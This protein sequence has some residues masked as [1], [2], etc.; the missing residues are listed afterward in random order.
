MLLTIKTIVNKALGF[1]G[2]IGR[3]RVSAAI[4]VA[5]VVLLP[6]R[7]HADKGRK[8]SLPIDAKAGV[9][10]RVVAADSA[11]ET[12]VLQL[13]SAGEQ[14]E[15]EDLIV[16]E[17]ARYPEAVRVAQLIAR[18]Q[19]D[20][21]QA[22]KLQNLNAVRPAQSALFLFACCTRSR[23]AIESASPFFNVVWM[24]DHKTPAAKCAYY[25]MA[26]DSQQLR[27][28]P[29]AVVD[30]VFRDLRKLADAHPDNLMIRWMLAVQ[31]RNWNRDEEGAEAYKLVLARWQPGPA[32]VHQT[33]ANLLDNLKRYDEALAERYL[34]VKMEPASW[35]YDGLANTLD[36]LSRFDESCEIHEIAVRMG[37]GRSLN[38]SNWAVALNGQGKHEEAIEKCQRALHL[39]AQNWRAHWMWGKALDGQGKPQEALE[40]CQTATAI[41]E[42]PELNDYI[43]DLKRRLNK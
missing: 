29:A 42:F 27:N 16:S 21:A 23:F 43:A 25:M 37:P 2:S 1:C 35:S 11:L 34:V 3:Y 13:L 26:M 9:N 40:K 41:F 31:C 30:R 4:V 33:Y 38:W 18:R 5:A 36:N 14:S 39:D 7:S 19:Y 28:E 15:A 32:L 6:A 10:Q 20:E 8:E 22:Y 12:Q 17:L 24:L